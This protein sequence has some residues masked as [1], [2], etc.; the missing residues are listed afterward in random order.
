MLKTLHIENVAVIEKADIQFMAGF[1]VLTGETGAGKSIIIDSLWAILGARTS[2][3]L[4]RHGQN[5]A[6]VSALFSP[7]SPA[8]AAKAEELGF[9]PEDDTLL[10][11]REIVQDGRNT[12]RINGRPASV[13]ILRQLGET[14]VNI[15]GQNAGI[16]LLDENSH[17]DYLDSFGGYQEVLEEYYTQYRKLL[18]LRR[19]IKEKMKQNA[20]LQQR[21][22][23]LRFRWEEIK[24]AALQPGEYER[25]RQRRLLLGN[26]EKISR[27]LMA[28]VTALSGN[29][30]ETGAIGLVSQAEERFR[31]CA[32]WSPECEGF[33][34]RSQEILALCQELERDAGSFLGTVDYSQ[35]ELA[36]TEERLEVLE[37]LMK[38]YAVDEEG[39]LRLEEESRREVEQLEHMGEDLSQLNGKYAALRDRVQALSQT[40]HDK[41]Q[42]AAKKLESRIEEEL[43]QL[44]MPHARFQVQVCH[45]GE[46]GH[47]KFTRR[48]TD[49]VRF[50]LTTNPG[51]D[52]KPL[53]RVAS[54]GELSRIMLAIKT[55]LTTAEDAST[56]I[57][58]EI[59][60]GVSGRAANKVGEKLFAL[61]MEK[62]VL[63]V[64]HLPQIAALGEHQYR[65]VKE[66]QGDKTLTQVELL[67]EEG[68]AMEIARLTAGLG[69]T[70]QTLRS[71]REILE[72]ARAFQEDC[73]AKK[74]LILRQW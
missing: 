53:A 9:P 38:K 47:I 60:T 44:D 29:D 37:R 59:D 61:S 1:N 48:G 2:R 69:V 21:E 65:I 24:S 43:H 13:S 58:D 36:Q 30:E 50:L 25:L 10:I 22:D 26:Q 74:A 54:G 52:Y 3:E 8:A 28:A 14:L 66:A 31:T 33:R 4:I 71:A 35:E 49:E 73:M 42:Q 72:I 27:S 70:Q 45:A 68:R 67:D 23:L 40:L 39:L 18:D 51:E 6:V 55:V 12:C 19:S 34:S 5:K 32:K 17:M 16:A 20:L 46:E 62:Q 56:L 15:H 63:C 11:S 41:R 64:T 7:L 57:F